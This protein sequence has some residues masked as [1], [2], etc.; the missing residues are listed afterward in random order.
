MN[1]E[2]FIIFGV[3]VNLENFKSFGVLVN[4]KNLENFKILGFI[5]FCGSG[6]FEDEVR[7]SSQNFRV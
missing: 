7:V 3:L 5:K 6:L 2:N 4:L 1:L